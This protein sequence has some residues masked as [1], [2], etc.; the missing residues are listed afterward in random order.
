[1]LKILAG[2]FH[3]DLQT[4]IRESFILNAIARIVAITNRMQRR[5]PKNKQ[6]Q[7]DMNGPNLSAIMGLE[8]AEDAINNSDNEHSSLMAASRAAAT[9]F[10]KYDRDDL[11]E[12][13][14]STSLDWLLSVS[15][16]KVQVEPPVG[17]VS[18]IKTINDLDDVIILIP[19]PKNVSKALELR[20]LHQILRELVTGIYILNQVPSLSL[21][22][23]FD[24]STSCQMPV[25]YHDTRVGQ[26]MISVDYMMKSIWHGAIFPA[27]KRSKFNE[28]W[29]QAV[30]LNIVTGEPETRRSHQHIWKEAGLM[31]LATEEDFQ[32]AFSNL[33]QATADDDRFFDEQKFFMKYVDDIAMV[34]AFGQKSIKN[35]F[36]MFVLDSSGEI[37]SRIKAQN[38]DLKA[39][40]RLQRQFHTQEQF[41]RQN[42][43]NK[44]QIRRDLTL[45]KLISLLVPMLIGL[46][47]KN[48]IP[49]MSK[50]LPP[51]THEE[52]KTDRELPPIVIT[53]DLFCKNFEAS[54][55]YVGLHGGISFMRETPSEIFQPS[56]GIRQSY[57]AI[58]QANENNANRLTRTGPLLDSY[59]LTPISIDNEQYYIFSFDIETYYPIT[60]KIPKLIHAHY[61]EI[62]KLKPKRLPLSEIQIHEQFRKRYGYQK[63]AKLKQAPASLKAAAQRG[64]SAVFNTICRRQTLTTLGSLDQQGMS[65]LHDAAIVDRPQIITQLVTLGLDVNVRKHNNTS[66]LGIMPIHLAACSGAG[67]SIA[68]LVAFRADLH[69]YD[70]IGFTAMHYAAYFNNVNC[71]KT[72]VNKDQSLLELKTKFGNCST[73]LLLASSSGAIEA[74]KLLI[75]LGADISACDSD[76]NSIVNNAVLHEHTHILVYFIEE[77]FPDAPVWKVLVTM[78]GDVNLFYRQ[79]AAKCLEALTLKRKEN[80]E[81][82]LK[83]DGIHALVSLLDATDVPLL[84]LVVSVLCNIGEFNEVREKVSSENAVQKLVA[85]LSCE[86]P[87]VHS[88]AAVILGD[89]GCIAENQMKI[90]S[91]GRYSAYI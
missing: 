28:R 9:Y 2:I 12:V 39:F 87:I 78:L 86:A 44:E 46:K 65:L 22:A 72:L 34:M 23:N 20:E 89:L 37:S 74:L 17:L 88:R 13:L 61:D 7:I 24:R 82:I 43:E 68:A 58:L 48:K 3:F 19:A 84:S 57:N 55:L 27:D 54:D 35:F 30:N 1:M 47:R 62:S 81:H 56:L 79:Q 77:S 76:G 16:T 69:A 73:P 80:W 11:Q 31:D 71:L 66:G 90:A 6:S 70:G 33:N 64:M 26:L 59:P 32:E 91:E 5:L 36:N 51:L 60:P 63:T 50:F 15:E 8:R 41:L 83:A 4:N 25:C 21:E 49:N 45:L 75:D 40:E 67:E 53:E 85:M 18:N 52:C 42:I 29:R 10:D 14:S 38:V